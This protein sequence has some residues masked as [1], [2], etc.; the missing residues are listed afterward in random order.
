M[1]KIQD[2][3]IGFI[4]TGV[5]GKSMAAHLLAAEYPLVVYSRT[6]DKASDLLEKGAIWAETPREVA[7][8]ASVIFTIVG[9]PVDVEEIYFGENGLIPN[10]KAGS[11]FVD[12]TTSAPSLA[13]KIY[14]EAKKRGMYAI[15]APV[16]G[17][18]IGAREA[19]L[20]IMVGGDSDAYASIRPILEH[21]GDN[22]VY[23]GK[24]GSGQHTK[25][26]NQ[27]AIASNMIGVC[28]AIVYAEKAGLNPETVLESIST[29]AAGS[30]SLSNL[31]PRMLNGNFEPG[32]YIKHFIKD[33]KIAIS[34]AELLGMEAPGLSLAKSLYEQ[35]A[36]NGEENSGTQALYKYWKK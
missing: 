11:Y 18:D 4:G 19:K 36:E 23:Q 28:E 5:M 16:S 21:L 14:E 20:S 29:G 30:W 27:I 3:I 7:E 10:G 35:L 22:I 9:Y 2:V 17:G 25:M 8:K 34:E 32:F 1:E 13:V 15:D 24:A 33:M 12:M 26:C 31:A 6:K